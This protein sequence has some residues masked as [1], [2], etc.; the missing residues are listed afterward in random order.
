MED[1]QRV[2]HSYKVSFIAISDFS[3]SLN[4]LFLGNSA[5]VERRCHAFVM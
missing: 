1:I 5:A 3:F 4:N 2:G